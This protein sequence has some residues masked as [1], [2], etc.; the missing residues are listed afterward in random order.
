MVITNSELK[1]AF[2]VDKPFKEVKREGYTLLGVN[3]NQADRILNA[4]VVLDSENKIER[5]IALTK[6]ATFSN[7]SEFKEIVNRNIVNMMKLGCTILASYHMSFSNNS[8]AEK[9]IFKSND[10]LLAFLI[11]GVHGVAVGATAVIKADG[12]E[13]D[14]EI[15]KIFASI[16]AF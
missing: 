15:S 3:Q 14:K 6:D 10:K 13:Y 8:T 12:D 2:N 4:F 5:A 7:E 16:T 1:F 11:T 9:I